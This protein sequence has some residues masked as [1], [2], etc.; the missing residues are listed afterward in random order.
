MWNDW[1][2]HDPPDDDAWSHESHWSPELIFGDPDA[3][4]GDTGDGDEWRGD[5]HAADWPEWTTGP[6][7]RRWKRLAEGNEKGE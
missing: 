5:V 7:Y 3:W 2:N 4:R 1:S 6:E